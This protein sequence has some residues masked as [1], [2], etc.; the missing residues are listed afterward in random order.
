MPDG[1]TKPYPDEHWNRWDMKA[2]L[3]ILH[4]DLESYKTLNRKY[5]S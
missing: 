1:S 4:E 5:Q 2:D 3:A